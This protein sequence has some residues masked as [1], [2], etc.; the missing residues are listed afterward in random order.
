MDLLDANDP[1]AAITKLSSALGFLM[2]A[3]AN[4]AGDL[5][6]LANLLGLAAEGIATT[7]YCQATVAIPNPTQG[8]VRALSSIAQMIASGHDLVAGRPYVEACGK[9]RQATQKALDLR[10]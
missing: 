5:S 7:A 10:R 9:F 2:T 6:A 8:Q 3:Q 4:G 1:A